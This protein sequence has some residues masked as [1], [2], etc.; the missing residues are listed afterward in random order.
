MLLSL[1]A[2]KSLNRE[3]ATKNDE[4]YIKWQPLLTIVSCYSFT[5]VSDEMDVTTFYKELS[6][7]VQHIPKHN[8]LIISG[9]MNAHIGKDKNNKFNLHNLTNKNGDYLAEFYLYNRNAGLNKL[10]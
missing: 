1:P 4:C 2:L 8:I 3:N 9:D 5:N 7:L 6:L 10:Q